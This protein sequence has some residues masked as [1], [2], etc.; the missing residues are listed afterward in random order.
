MRS[1]PSSTKNACWVSQL[2]FR[3]VDPFL[4]FYLDLGLI[5]ARTDACHEIALLQTEF[6]VGVDR[7]SGEKIVRVAVRASFV[8]RAGGS[9]D[10]TI[11]GHV[12]R[13]S[14]LSR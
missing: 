14:A 13:S 11:H 9:S 6:A 8:D 5:A 10:V 12:M 7:P 1:V 2:R 4:D 3:P